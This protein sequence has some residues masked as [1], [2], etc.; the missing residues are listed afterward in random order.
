MNTNKRVE[1]SKSQEVYMNNSSF[2]WKKKEVYVCASCPKMCREEDSGQ[3]KPLTWSPR[4]TEI[5]PKLCVS[6]WKKIESILNTHFCISW[7]SGKREAWT[8]AS[9]NVL[10]FQV[11]TPGVGGALTA[12]VRNS[13][14]VNWRWF[15]SITVSWGIM[16]KL[17]VTMNE[18]MLNFKSH[19]RKL[20]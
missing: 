8:G 12:P 14:P 2:V 13:S 11:W 16:M 18:K 17:K 9:R 6:L 7:L 15:F 19:L 5:L 4:E 1:G 10:G 20:K 3:R